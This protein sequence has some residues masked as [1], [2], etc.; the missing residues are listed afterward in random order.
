MINIREILMG[1]SRLRLVERVK[2]EIWSMIR[3]KKPM[4]LM[5]WVKDLII[6]VHGE[7]NKKQEL[8]LFNSKDYNF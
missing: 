8:S 5:N 1:L 7:C 2:F 3:V 6:L 4:R